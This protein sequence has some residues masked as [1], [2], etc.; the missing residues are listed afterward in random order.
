[1][2]APSIYTGIKNGTHVARVFEVG[3]SL[4]SLGRRGDVGWRRNGFGGSKP[5][6]LVQVVDRGKID[7]ALVALLLV[8][9]LA[10]DEYEGLVCDVWGCVGSYGDCLERMGDVCVRDGVEEAELGCAEGDGGGSCPLWREWL[11]LRHLSWRQL[12]STT[13]VSNNNNNI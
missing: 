7:T 8:V 4:C 10:Y 11:W 1:M 5:Q 12:P 3:D 6:E 9:E 2:S 13:D